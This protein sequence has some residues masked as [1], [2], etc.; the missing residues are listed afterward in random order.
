MVLHNIKEVILM[1]KRLSKKILTIA[2]ATMLIASTGAVSTSAVE[3][4]AE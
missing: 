3:V 4:A 2:M 1:L